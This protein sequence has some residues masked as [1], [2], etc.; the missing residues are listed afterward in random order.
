MCRKDAAHADLTNREITVGDVRLHCAEMGK[1]E[2]V[3]LLHGFPEFWYSWRHQ[4]SA[5]A[6]AGFRA[7]APDLRGYNR[8]DRP[9]GIGNYR[10]TK[11][12]EDVAGVIRQFGDGPAFVVGHDWGGILAWRLAALRPHLVRR[13]AILNAPHPSAFRRELKR[14]PLQ[15][16]RSSYVLFFQLPWLPEQLLSAHNFALL[17]RSWRRQPAR[18][19]AFGDQEIAEYKRALSGPNGLVGPLN[20]YRAALRYPLELYS[21]PQLI[22]APTLLIWG[23]RDPFLSVRLTEDLETWVPDLKVVRIRDASHWVQNEVS[24]TVN[25]ELVDFLRG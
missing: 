1:G 24:G 18:Q 17:E 19:E 3:F 21:S 5:L 13:L 14:N 16:L 23:E 7:V 6:E 15:W 10:V 4:L 12:I 2:P 8:S 20:Y 22:T 9:A 25:R 11:L